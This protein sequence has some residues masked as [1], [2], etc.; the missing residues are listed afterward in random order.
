M[1]ERRPDPARDRTREAPIAALLTL[2]RAFFDVCR[3]RR[4]PQDIPASP[5][6]LTLSL[7]AYAATAAVLTVTSRPAVPALGAG[8]VEAL[9]I[10][11]INF[12]LLAL[13]RLDGRWMQTTTA[14]AGT[15]TLFTLAA[16][17]LFAGMA[18][19]DGNGGVAAL[20][21][22]ALLLLLIWNVAVT[23]HILRHA[24]SLPFPAALIVA[25]AYAWVIAA[26]ITGMFPEPA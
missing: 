5:E 15:G 24:L 17:P 21:Y 2:F 14:M 13:R 10:A 16:L 6:L 22:A 11:G 20:L 1:P 26:A 9:L 3:L 25:A 8:V 19:T 12:A 18:G 23:A 7:L 4:G